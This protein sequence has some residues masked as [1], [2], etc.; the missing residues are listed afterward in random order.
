MATSCIRSP[1]SNNFRCPMKRRGA[2]CGKTSCS[3]GGRS[4]CLQLKSCWD[5]QS[6]MVQFN[7][8]QSCLPPSSTEQTNYILWDIPSGHVASDLLEHF[9]ST[10]IFLT[11]S[12]SRGF[13]M[14]FPGVSHG[15]STKAQSNNAQH[16]VRLQK[17]PRA[18]RQ[19]VTSGENHGTPPMKINAVWIMYGS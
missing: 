13:P 14:D 2:L 19:R 8:I 1:L 15:F 9:P 18:A 4:E 10:K 3:F 17:M 6:P 11:S 16:I 7:I 5:I 12:V